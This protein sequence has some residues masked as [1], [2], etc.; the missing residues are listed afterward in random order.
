MN[1]SRKPQSGRSGVRCI[2]LGSG[3][4]GGRT[5]PRCSRCS[6]RLG[7]AADGGGRRTGVGGRRWGRLARTVGVDLLTSARPDTIHR[8]RDNVLCGQF[9]FQKWLG[10]ENTRRAAPPKTHRLRTQKNT[11]PDAISQSQS[12]QSAV[13]SYQNPSLKMMQKPRKKLIENNL[14]L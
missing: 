4:G 11:R 10:A 9:L 7:G 13:N 8:G 14:F 6:P 5:A 2:T 12:P 3:L 1:S